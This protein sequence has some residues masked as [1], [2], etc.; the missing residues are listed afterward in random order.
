MNR[1]AFFASIPF[2]VIYVLLALC[3]ASCAAG[4]IRV[5]GRAD[6]R[7]T[8]A[9]PPAAEATALIL[10]DP[11]ISRLI[12]PSSASIAVTVERGGV[13]VAEKSVTLSAYNATV[14]VTVS[15]IPVDDASATVTVSC[16]NSS[17]LAL[18]RGSTDV[19]INT[20]G[21]IS[22]SLMLVPTE[23]AGQTL[24]IGAINSYGQ[25]GALSA[26]A[27]G[28]TLYRITTTD[29][30]GD[31]AL[32]AG[33]TEG[34]AT[35]YS[36]DGTVTA[37][38]GGTPE[39]WTVLSFG[40]TVPAFVLFA[41]P[42]S[43]APSTTLGVERAVYVTTTG[44]GSGTKAAP[45]SGASFNTTYVTYSGPTRFLLAAGDYPGKFDLFN[46]GSIYGG[47]DSTFTTRDLGTYTTRFTGTFSGTPDQIL[48]ANAVNFAALD[49]LTVTPNSTLEGGVT[50]LDHAT[51]RVVNSGVRIS[52]CTIHTPRQTLVFGFT[53]AG[54]VI[55]ALYI[56]GQAAG[57]PI[58][59]ICNSF[60]GRG[61]NWAL[62][63]NSGGSDA[64]VALIMVAATT[65]D[66]L[67]GGNVLDG[68]WETDTGTNSAVETAGCV[69]VASNGKQPWIVG[70]TIAAAGGATTQVTLNL[71]AV[72][73][74]YSLNGYLVNNL[75]FAL[76]EYQ[77]TVA[78]TN[79]LYPAGST[80]Q[81]NLLTW[82]YLTTMYQGARNSLYFNTVTRAQTVT[83]L[84][85]VWTNNNA[86]QASNNSGNPVN[87]AV[88]T[89]YKATL[90]QLFVDFDGPTDDRSVYAARDY[91][92]AATAPA[93]VQTGGL[94]LSVA[95]NLPSGF[96]AIFVPYIRYDREG[97]A[98]TPGAWS[99]GADQA[100]N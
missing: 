78:E 22:V 12:D 54:N 37:K 10:N 58:I 60:V 75:I 84:N 62:D 19:D 45:L 41:A 25:N 53:T 52:G 90:D 49:G 100:G 79:L 97:K 65:A 74:G 43:G 47:F 71:A 67:I 16:L 14:E 77:A 70:N 39:Q 31:Y 46:G 88:Y 86:T 11:G 80:N 23:I 26:S 66:V 1:K 6:L 42:A 9:V 72:R 56:Q 68:G 32:S 5:Q 92:L 40:G 57:M 3:I 15:D 24:N 18:C 50:A 83:A 81:F 4:V 73:G 93:A 2:V 69:N 76:K 96:P 21:T 48:R 44:S 36:S 89:D 51:I 61:Q 91:R 98:R 33:L 29:V 94:D 95:G 30:L 82:N 28:A 7:L 99:I 87:S 35:F 13:T 8:I 63:F 64:V 17:G 34:T 85:L 59:A 38:I 55:T 27:G 20:V